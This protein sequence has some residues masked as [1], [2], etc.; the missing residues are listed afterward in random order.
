MT[1][2]AKP[3]AAPVP[4]KASPFRGR[5]RGRVLLLLCVMYA[6][7]YIDR[8]NISTA[9]PEMAK[10]LDLSTTAQGAIVS[11]F[12]LPYAFVQMGGGWLGEK[13]GPRRSLLAIGVL[14]GVATI[15]TG[16]AGGVLSL[17][18][19]RALLGLTEGSAFPTATQAMSRWIPRDRNGFAQGIVHSASRLGNALA[20]LLVAAIIAAA[21][22][23]E[24]FIYVGLLSAIWAGF[25]W[26]LFR[27]RPETA[28]GISQRE[29]DELPP[30]QV[31]ATRPP[32]PWRQL[33]KQILPVSFVDFGYGWTLWVFLTWIPSFLADSYHLPLTTYAGYTSVIL[34]AGVIGDTVGGIVSDRLIR[35]AGD[36]RKARRTVL[37]IGLVGSAVCLL[38][39]LFSH[40]LWLASASLMLSFFFLELTNANLWAIPM[41]VAPQWSGTASGMMNTGY[42]FAG[43]F[44]PIVFGWLV[45]VSGWQWPFAL[46]VALL[47]GA[48]IVAW[49]MNPR[50]L[51]VTDGVLEIGVP[52][53]ERIA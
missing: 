46:S 12:A 28:P 35:R 42:G 44:S 2:A 48:A 43:V 36:A 22:W 21:G 3:A 53:A 51:T 11:A 31:R 9:L 40:H 13:I 1:T 7:S 32:V 41:D 38:P 30:A 37:L 18:L 25:W 52:A 34:L 15:W 10:D 27:D 23:R 26:F 47:L 19:A 5:L 16:L 17:F 20:P 33:I 45:G 50:R 14:W 39:L 8:T 6:I 29:L 4:V 24:S 49:F